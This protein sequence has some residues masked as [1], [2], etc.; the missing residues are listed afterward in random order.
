MCSSDLAVIARGKNLQLFLSNAAL[1]TETDDETAWFIDFDA[2]SHM[3]CNKEWYD[4]YYEKN[5][6]THIYLGDN[7]SLKVQ[8]YG[9]I[10][11]YL[12]NGQIR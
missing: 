4:K 5:D 10:S 7:R 8:G 1:S 6:G 11:V 3:T 9:I 2:S 12:P